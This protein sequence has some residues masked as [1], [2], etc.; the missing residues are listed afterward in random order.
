MNKGEVWL[1]GFFLNVI[2]FK[3]MIRV[4]IINIISMYKLK[5][6]SGI[7][8]IKCPEKLVTYSFCLKY[9]V[10]VNQWSLPMRTSLLWW[11]DMRLKVPTQPLTHKCTHA[12]TA[13]HM[14]TVLL[15]PRTGTQSFRRNHL[16]AM[17]L[18][19]LPISHLS[20][21]PLWKRPSH[22]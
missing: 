9:F 18:T 10:D 20:D 2:F 21:A 11:D 15:P 5:W 8:N 17:R 7:K 1:P 3:C 14:H 12:V 4:H 13:K 19:H 22:Y 16:H 6:K